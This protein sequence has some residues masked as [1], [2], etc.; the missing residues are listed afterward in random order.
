MDAANRIEPHPA[1]RTHPGEVLRL[2]LED[3]LNM[4]LAEAARQL[5][6]SRQALHNVISGKNGISPD[7]ALLLGRMVGSPRLWMNLQ[8]RYDLDQARE[9]MPKERLE[10]VPELQ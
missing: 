1:M 8:A 2:M 9:R 4:S 5:G 6:V 7:M 10:R 3:G